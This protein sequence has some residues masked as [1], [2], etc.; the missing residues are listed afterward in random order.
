MRVQRGEGG[1]GGRGAW[2]EGRGIESAACKFFKIFRAV[3][4]L[5]V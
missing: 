2:F 1:K 5:A 3:L 4:T